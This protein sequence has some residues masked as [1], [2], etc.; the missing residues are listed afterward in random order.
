MEVRTRKVKQLRKTLDRL[1]DEEIFGSMVAG[2]VKDV[3]GRTDEVDK[4][5]SK[6]CWAKVGNQTQ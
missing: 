3:E 5:N 4:N 6:S 2:N 1:V